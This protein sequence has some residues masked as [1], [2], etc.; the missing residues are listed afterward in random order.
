MGSSPIQG[1]SSDW[2][3]ITQSAYKD[4]REYFDGGVRREIEKD[5]RQ[6]QGLHPTDSKYLSDAYKARSKFFRPKTRATIRRNEAVAASALFSNTDVVEV[7]AW[8]ESDKTQQAAAMLQ[9]ELLNLRLKHNIPW[10][11]VAIGGYQS[12]QAEGLVC[13]HPYWKTDKKRDIDQPMVDLI[14]I[15]NMVFSPAASWFD[16][17]NSSPYLIRMIPMYVKDVQARMK[18]T[19]KTATAKWANLDSNIILQ[20]VKSYS[21]SITLV[22]DNN[23]PDRQQAA[24]SLQPYQTVW[25]YETIADIDGEDYIWHTLAETALLAPGKP[26]RSVYWHGKRPYVIGYAVLE[27][28]KIYPPGV[29]R[30]TRE[31]QGE[32]NEN[33]NQRSDNVKFAM[34]KR[35]F[36]KRGAQLDIRSLV[37]NVPSSVTLMNDPEKDVH[38]VETKDVTQSAFEE[39]D[40]LNTDFDE[41]AGSNS[42]ASRGDPDN[43]A[44][45][46]GGA[47]MLSEDAN[48]IEGYQLRTYVET[49]IEPVLTQIMLLEQ[50]YETDEAVLKLCGKKAQLQEDHGIN[51]IDDNLLMQELTLTV[52]VGIGSTSPRKQLDNLLFALSKIVE[53]LSTPV[54]S[55]YGLDVEELINEIFSRIGYRTADRFFKWNDQDPQIMALNAQVQDLT[56]ALKNKKDPPE[57]VA[58]K[59]SLLQAQVKKTLSDAFNVNVEGLF[60]S[61]QAAEVV[62]AVPAVAPV[63]DTIAKAAGYQPPV[64]A[65]VDPGIQPAGVPSTAPAGPPDAGAPPPPVAAQPAPPSGQPAMGGPVAAPTGPAP[66]LHIDP[67]GVTNKRTGIGFV[68]GSTPKAAPGPVAADGRAGVKPDGLPVG[69]RENTSPQS[70]AVVGKPHALGPT[71][72]K[73]PKLASS[74][75]GA[76]AGIEGGQT[77]A[78][79]TRPLAGGMPMTPGMEPADPEVDAVAQ[80]GRDKEAQSHKVDTETKAKAT[81][82]DKQAAADI[83]VAKAAPKPPRPAAKK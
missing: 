10:F 27:S 48:Q 23:R 68:P 61:M 14:P 15:E 30:L 12:A 50:H 32:L 13:A 70:H 22:R 62:A 31:L 74:D 21:D 78:H 41:I 17:V 57:V 53:L 49:F 16:V 33:A 45:K 56:N 81:L 54:L 35:Y 25:V 6:F 72:L 11:H 73:T 66:G 40:R 26:L 34:N 36:G 59:V 37:R 20:A 79:P 3:Q 77:S 83:R 38:V 19:G 5:V 47:E 58:A 76:H 1:A 51:E 4:G 69:V 46:V 42:K 75:V 7:G 24:T 82:I 18:A 64:P 28:H 65:G 71:P 63:A 2:L 60:G 80:H 55:Q 43:L 8:D 52:H 29:S 67:K 44:N 9:K 39:Q